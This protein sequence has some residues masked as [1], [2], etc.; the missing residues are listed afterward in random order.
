[1]SY[2][3]G[4]GPHYPGQAHPPYQG[5]YYHPYPPHHYGSHPYGQGGHS[6]F[7]QNK[8]IS[9][10]EGSYKKS[11]K[12]S[13][14]PDGGI[15]DPGFAIDDKTA[16]VIVD[17]QVDF[18]SPHGVAWGVVGKSV[19]ANNTTGNLVKLFKSA[20]E[21]DVTVFISPHYY[22]PWDHQWVFQGAGE[23]LMHNIHMFDRKGPLTLAGF[24]GSGADWMPE[25]KTYIDQ[26]NVVVCSPHKI[27]GPQTN[28]LALQLRKHGYGKLILAGMSA[29]LCV[30]SHL[31]HLVEEGFEV[32]VAKDATAG[33]IIPDL[34][35][36]GYKAALGNFRL[37]ASHV[38]TTAEVV[39]GF[40]QI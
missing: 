38:F 3:N 20:A 1:M 25:F 8:K 15:P 7:H 17:P 40:Q 13:Q 34:D 12:N 33:T 21:N 24:E 11:K 9:S 27:Y 26:P 35:I 4:Y 16:L 36:D 29:N 14:R 10:H 28:D 30:E 6:M 19:Q 2:Y 39:A 31:R 37:I 32:A 18:L 22:Y 23:A 5:P